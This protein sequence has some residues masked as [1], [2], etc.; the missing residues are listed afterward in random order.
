MLV[1]NELA[2][3]LLRG[4]DKIAE[5][6]FGDASEAPKVYHLVRT[7]ILPTFRMGAVICAR[8]TTL[9]G[10]IAEREKASTAA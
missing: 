6:I 2:P 1:D 3:D 5:F 8:R 10:W 7:G 9:L 4:A